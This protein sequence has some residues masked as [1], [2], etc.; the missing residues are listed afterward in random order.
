MR[1]YA[2]NLVDFSE[3]DPLLKFAIFA[4]LAVALLTLFVGIIG[5][6]GALKFERCLL[7]SVC[8]V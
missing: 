5:C 2:L 1:T 8:V 7:A 4:I 6:M 3:D